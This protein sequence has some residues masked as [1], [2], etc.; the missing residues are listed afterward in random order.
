M[1]EAAVTTSNR[2]LGTPNSKTRS[3]LVAA[4]IRVLKDH[5]YGALTSR[6]VAEKAGL[7]PQLVHYYFR[8][9]DDLVLSLV[10]AGGEE[11]IRHT[12]E[13]AQSPEPLRAFWKTFIDP[14][15][16]S[17]TTEVIS[18]AMHRESIR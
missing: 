18:M 2:R 3:A 17:L 10:H 6:L 14:R 8:T 15:S 1:N 7:K 12:M 4:A 11:G 9:M 16:A 5:G 13:A